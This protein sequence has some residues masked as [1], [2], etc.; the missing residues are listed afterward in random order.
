MNKE[1]PY[2]GTGSDGDS[3]QKRINCPHCNKSN[4]CSIY[5]LA[6]LK[7]DTDDTMKIKCVRCKKNIFIHCTYDHLFYF[8]A[9]Q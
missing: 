7:P 9:K 1:C 8:G 5:S 6:N 2:C 3:E 4:I